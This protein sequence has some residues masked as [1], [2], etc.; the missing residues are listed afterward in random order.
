MFKSIFKEIFDAILKFFFVIMTFF[1]SNRRL[2]TR[3]DGSEAEEDKIGLLTSA[4]MQEEAM[5]SL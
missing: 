3:V 1:R 2:E 4:L 5:D